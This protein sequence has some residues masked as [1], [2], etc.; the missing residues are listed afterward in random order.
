[1][2]N[3]HLPLFLISLI[4]AFIIVA[5]STYGIFCFVMYDKYETIRKYLSDAI[6]FMKQHKP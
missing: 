6:S 2:D 4:F 3:F 5:V 1:M